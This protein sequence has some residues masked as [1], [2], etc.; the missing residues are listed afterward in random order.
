MQ[1]QLNAKDDIYVAADRVAQS[2]EFALP[3]ID[4]G[5][6]LIGRLD[7]GTAYKL[8]S[9]RAESQLMASAGW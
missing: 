7:M 5:G 8:Q 4:D 3:V 1:R 6:L 2:E 9:E